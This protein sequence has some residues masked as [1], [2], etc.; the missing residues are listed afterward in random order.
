MT[1]PDT[2]DTS[3]T[4]TSRQTAMKS[5]ANR[6]RLFYRDLDSPVQEDEMLDKPRIILQKIQFDELGKNHD[7]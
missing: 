7:K 3:A 4:V 6:T 5:H 1:D 2:N